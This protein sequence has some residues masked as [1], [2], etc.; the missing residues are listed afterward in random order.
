MKRYKWVDGNM[1]GLLV[2]KSDSLEKF[3]P[4][5]DETNWTKILINFLVGCGF[6]SAVVY[7]FMTNVNKV[8]KLKQQQVNLEMEQ[9][10]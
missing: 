7:I 4:Q 10:F 8:G 3:E 6:I 9:S 1:K 5:S 2:M